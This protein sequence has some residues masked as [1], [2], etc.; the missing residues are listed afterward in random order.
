M[1]FAIFVE[2][3]REGA[4]RRASTERGAKQNDGDECDTI[5][6]L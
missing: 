1:S 2:N 3:E 5:R 4:F 6:D